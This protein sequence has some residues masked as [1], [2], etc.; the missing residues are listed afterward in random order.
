MEGQLDELIEKQ[1]VV[2]EEIQGQAMDYLENLFRDENTVA[3][4]VIRLLSMHL[5]PPRSL[6]KLIRQAQRDHGIDYADKQ[7]QA[8]ALCF[9]SAIALITGKS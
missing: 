7:K 6:E 4:E 9:Q 5:E 2:E 1:Q 8:M 3:R